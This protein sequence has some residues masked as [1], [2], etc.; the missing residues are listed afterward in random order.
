MKNNG[1]R[2]MSIIYPNVCVYK[3]TSIIINNKINSE[4]KWNKSIDNSS[5][6]NIKPN[7]FYDP[8]VICKCLFHLTMGLKP[9][10]N[11]RL[12]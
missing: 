5:V 7:T 10:N 3:R 2:K 9:T 6:K 12:I 8:T 1:Q 4:N 11:S